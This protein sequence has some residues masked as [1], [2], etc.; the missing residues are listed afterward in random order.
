MKKSYFIEDANTITIHVDDKINH[1]ILNRCDTIN[2]IINVDLI[3]GL[4]IFHSNNVNYIYYQIN[5]MILTK[6][7]LNIIRNKN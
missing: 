2:L 6:V 3:S 5:P 1:L 4:D 7:Y